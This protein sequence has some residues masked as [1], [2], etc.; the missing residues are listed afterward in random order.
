MKMHRIEIQ[1]ESIP[2]HSFFAHAHS[3]SLSPSLSFCSL[4]FFLVPP[5]FF[6]APFLSLFVL[7]SFRVCFH[8]WVRAWFRGLGV[9]HSSFLSSPFFSAESASAAAFFLASFL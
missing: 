6:S 4:F 7:L 2:S 1:G 5:L 8:S 9:V 3:F